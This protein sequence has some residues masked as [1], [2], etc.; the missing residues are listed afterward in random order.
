MWQDW[1]ELVP[2]FGPIKKYCNY[3]YKAIE[4]DKMYCPFCNK[5]QKY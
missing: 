2:I 3:C 4:K 5:L 1:M